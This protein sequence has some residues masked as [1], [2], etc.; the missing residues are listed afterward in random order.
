MPV[1]EICRRLPFSSV[2]HYQFVH[3][4]DVD[5]T[6]DAV[7]PDVEAAWARSA[8]ESGLLYLPHV[9]IGWDNNPRFEALRP[10]I[11]RDN[12]PEAFGR[13]MR[14]AVAAAKATGAPMVTVNSWNEWTEGS[15]LEPDDRNGYGYLE[16][17][18]QAVL[19]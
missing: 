5:R 9:S 6:Y 2:T 10:K 11:L 16:A 18:R 14:H 4:V 7:L 3:F 15:Y 12:T 17:V 13:A 8:G 1:R 19:E